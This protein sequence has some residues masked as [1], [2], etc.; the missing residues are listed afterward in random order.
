[1]KLYVVRHGQTDENASGIMQGRT[2]NSQLNRIGIMQATEVKNKLKDIK[3][4]ACFTSPLIRSW[5]TAMI[6]AGDK[7][8]IKQDDRLIERYLGN[9]EGKD[10]ET[11]DVEKYWDYKANYSG[12]GVESI[13]DIL[14]RCEDFINYLKE[15]YKDDDNI[16][17]V[18]HSAIVKM[19][20]NI[21]ENKDY[22]NKLIA[23]DIKNCYYKCYDI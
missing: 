8:E 6:I 2:I 9:L 23:Y 12:E 5:S 3:F 16:L 11:Y 14:N 19:M 10:R 15:N 17:I 22:P 1:M 4:T 18:T 20:Q 21:F 7:V 13:R